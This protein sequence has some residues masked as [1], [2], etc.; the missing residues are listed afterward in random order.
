[1]LHRL[2]GALF[3]LI[4]LGSIADGWR[5]ALQA[6]SGANFDAIGPDRYLMA[7][8]VVMLAAGLWRLLRQPE[9]APQASNAEASTG[10]LPTLVL[11]LGLVAGFALIIPVLGFSPAC[12][13]FVAVLLRV[14][15]G[16]GWWRSIAMAVP[17]ALGFH[18]AFVTFADMPFPKGYFGI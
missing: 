8:G 17:I 4:G 7:L 16:W 14:L 3:V 1:M 10:M 13:L 2:H 11:T 15:S 18:V 9:V 12:F 5:I 6:R